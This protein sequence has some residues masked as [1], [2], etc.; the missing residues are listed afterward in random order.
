MKNRKNQKGFTLVELA[1]VLVIIGLILGSVM[2]GQELIQNAKYK[3]LVNDL[4]GLAAAFYTYYDR[5]HAYPGDDP[6][7][8]DRWSSSY[9][10]I[11]GGNGDGLINGYPNS[12]TNTDESVQV[13]RHLRAA[14]IIP[15]DPNESSVTRPSNPYGGR[16]GFSFRNFG[17]AYYNYIFVDN[18][19][20]EIAKRLDEEF[21]DGVWDKGSIQANA[22][23]TSGVRDI[24][25]RL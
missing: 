19:P 7:A 3:R 16:Y 5:Y 14:G 20:A 11:I 6:K 13:W 9:S 22:D 18:L 1:I 23:Y 8:G 17:S 15:G 4:R 21:D 12:A 10:N 2:K 25:Y 24:Y